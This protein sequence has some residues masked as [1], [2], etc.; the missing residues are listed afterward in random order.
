MLFSV[1]FIVVLLIGVF[2]LF[3]RTGIFQEKSIDS[4]D[5]AYWNYTKEGIISGTEQ[6]SLEGNKDTCWLLIH[7]YTGTPY[8]MKELAEEINLE[9]G[10]FVFVPRL[11][12]HGEVP[13]HV[14]ELNL[15]DWYE[16][17]EGDYSF[18]EGFCKKINV[19]GFSFG[20][21]LATKISEEKEVKN[22]YLIAPY[23]YAKYEPIRIFRIETYLKF[24]GEKIGYS[25]K[26]EI[27]QINSKEGREKYI[28]YWNF[29]IYSVINSQHFLREMEIN[30]WKINNSILIQHS[31]NDDTADFES[32]KVIYKGVSSNDKEIIK[33]TKSNHVLLFDYDK[34]E[35]IKSIIGFEKERR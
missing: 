22:T 33:Y 15:N 17:M 23:I 26:V 29:P 7:G 12:G 10:D 27:A 1:G 19:V 18:L 24:F 5:L 21:A 9:F 35:V 34:E 8:E 13:S 16:Q 32:S 14:K 20:G 2:F 31:L 4:K 30:L 6:F 3:D 11:K 28:S 25:K